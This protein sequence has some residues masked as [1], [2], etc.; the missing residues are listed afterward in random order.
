M[1]TLIFK[2]L[3]SRRRRNGWLM[4]E[5]ILVTIISWVV[6]DPVIVLTHD[7]M[8]PSGFDDDRLCVVSL[9]VLSPQAPGY[10]STATDST[11]M[12]D[13]YLGL[14]RTTENFEGVEMAAPLYGFSY[15]GS[16][17]NA[18]RILTPEGDSVM[19]GINVVQFLPHTRFFETFGFAPGEGRTPE[20]LS[21]YDY[22][23]G[24]AVLTEG[25]ARLY[26][27]TDNPAGKRYTMYH[28]EYNPDS[29]FYPIIGVVQD[30][31]YRNMWRPM[32]S[33]FMATTID[34][35][36][37]P[38]YT[39][40]LIRLKPGVSPKR[41]VEQFR[42]WM[43]K[44]LRR[45]NLFARSVQSYSDLIK[46]Q[47]EVTVMPT[48]RTNLLMAAFFL[49]NLCLGVIG[50]F[51]LQTRSRREEVGVMLAFGATPRK[52]IRLLMGE[53]AVLTIVS[54]LIGFFL[55]LQYAWSEGLSN[56]ESANVNLAFSGSNYWVEHFASHF[57]V[58]SAIILLILLAVVW[59][60]I[61]LPARHIS[62][63]PPT[64][65]LRDE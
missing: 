25:T 56:G 12:V 44:E 65:A 46:A 7:R 40:I 57:L 26:Y 13:A 43:V 50:T 27:D 61:Y 59:T 47:E 21:D 11:S 37:I 51:W 4:A 8:L 22:Q 24:D 15:P 2:N 5:L 29:T 49:I 53:G 23:E 14:V 10:V 36:D 3:W 48:Y 58:V 6:L 1:N 42:P 30:F 19:Y 28:R 60:G 31:K 52:I 17:G 38:E 62:R 55:Y 34:E 16:N 20:E 45:G 18:N 39:R 64:E 32:P 41:F 63:V 33:A 54:A 9:A 35:N